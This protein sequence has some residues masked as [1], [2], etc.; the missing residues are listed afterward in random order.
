MA[1]KR[2]KQVMKTFSFVDFWLTLFMN[3]RPCYF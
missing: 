2:I 1:K 3:V